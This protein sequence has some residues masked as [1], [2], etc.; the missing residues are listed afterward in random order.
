MCPSP[1]L[2]A[3]M[4]SNC[5]GDT[6]PV[7]GGGRKQQN[8]CDAHDIIPCTHLGSLVSGYHFVFRIDVQNDKSEN[9]NARGPTKQPTSNHF[10]DRPVQ[11]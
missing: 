4:A 7:R 11:G 8:A 2:T 10:F 9:R 5:R 6:K 3:A 1:P